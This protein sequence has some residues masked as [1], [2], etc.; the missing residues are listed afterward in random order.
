MLQTVEKLVH[1]HQISV[2]GHLQKP[3]KPEA[4]FALLANWAPSCP[5]NPSLATVIY[6]ANQVS[7]AIIQGEL[8]N[9]YQPQVDV[10]SGKV[11]GVECLVRWLHPHVG[12]VHPEHFI[13]V[14]EDHGLIDDLT[15]IVIDNAFAQAKIWQDNGL[16]LRVAVNVSMDNLAK[17]EFVDYL[18]AAVATAGIVPD[19]ITLEVTESRLMKGLSVPLE[20]L[21]RLR[22]K[23]FGL[24]IDDFGTGHSSLAQLRSIP[25]NELKVDK[26]F[27]HG[28]ARDRTLR[29]IYDASLGLAKHLGMTMVAEGVEERADWDLLRSTGCDQAQGYFIAQPMTADEIPAW[30]ITW[31]AS[32]EKLMAPPD[33]C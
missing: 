15:H 10:A 33:G 11:V 5:H 14:A 20:I 17:L 27:V 30:I 26:G 4:L 2:L 8:V 19:G 1:A 16:C 24:S 9:Y 32:F 3:I 25:F 23:G 12:L 7:A 21:T 31:E 22:L 13:S 6:H 18:M 29:A 28:I